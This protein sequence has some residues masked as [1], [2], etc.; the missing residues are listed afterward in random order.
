[1]QECDGAGN[2]SNSYSEMLHFGCS[3]MKCLEN[4][5]PPVVEAPQWEFAW[6]ISVE[7]WRDRVPRVI[8]GQFAP[9]LSVP[10]IRRGP[11]L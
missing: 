11:R 7:E 9:G 1:M 6:Q 5:F 3:T 8:A 10:I 2:V 4:R